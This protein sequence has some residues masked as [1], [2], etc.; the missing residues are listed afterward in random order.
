MLGRKKNCEGKEAKKEIRRK[1]S[2][3]IPDFCQESA[4]T[5]SPYG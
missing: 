4:I 2:K 1:G 5:I 3:E